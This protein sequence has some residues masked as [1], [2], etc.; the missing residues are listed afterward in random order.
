MNLTISIKYDIRNQNQ[1]IFII[2]VVLATAFV[3]KKIWD[4][5]NNQLAKSNKEIQDYQKK[6]S[7]AGEIDGLYKQFAKFK[8]VGWV[9][10]ESVTIMGRI[11]DLASKHGIEIINFDPVGL[12]EKTNYSVFSLKLSIR[13]D[14][15]SLSRFLS[16]IEELK[17]LTKVSSLEITPESYFSDRKDGPLIEA[18]LTIR[19]FIAT[20]K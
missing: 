12:D 5:Q 10:A 6:I 15:F 4:A 3:G 8:G 2:A 14:Y 1:I 16:E 20:I 18:N 11:N 9:T 7:I 19:A 13:A 17:T